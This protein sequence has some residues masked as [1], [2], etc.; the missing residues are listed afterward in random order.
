MT[1]QCGRIRMGRI[2]NS[3]ESIQNLLKQQKLESEYMS[4]E[5]IYIPF[6][7]EYAFVLESVIPV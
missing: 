4:F 2:E 6:T 7:K 5:S 1:R 3:T